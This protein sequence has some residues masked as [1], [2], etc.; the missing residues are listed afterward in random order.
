TG[1][2]FFI[3][4]SAFNLFVISVF[5]SLMLDIF[6]SDQAKRLF[7]II[8]AGGSCGAIAGPAITTFM[9]TFLDV[10]DLFLITTVLLLIATRL[11]RFLEI[12][13]TRLNTATESNHLI[14]GNSFSAFKSVINSRYQQLIALFIIIYTG[15]STIFYFEQ[16]KLL[17]Q[18]IEHTTER[19]R[20]FSVI[21]LSSNSL[22]LLVQ[23]LISGRLFSRFK[24]GLSLLAL[25]VLSIVAFLGLTLENSLISIAIIMICYRSLNF[26]M[27]RP[28]RELLYQ[29][30]DQHDRFKS[31]NLVDTVI[32][33]GGDAMMA[34]LF[35]LLV[36]FGLSLAGIAAAAL[37]LAIIWIVLGRH[38]AMS[39]QEKQ[40]NLSN[41]LITIEVKND[42][43]KTSY[44]T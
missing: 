26:S 1:L 12:N 17:E 29:I 31:K 44:K 20:Y 9:L 24:L 7:G 33:R 40:F 21:D 3:W 28:S 43:Q 10:S 34:W 23:F 6:T 30:L 2:V 11:I 5:W 36:S 15:V 13:N 16:A 41:Q 39:Y 4:L 8:A 27:Q 14:G 35:S 18:T 37:P 19:I 22:T 38:I 32:Y 42:E 25:P